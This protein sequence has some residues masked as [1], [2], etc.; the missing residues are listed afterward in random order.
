MHQKIR[1]GKAGNLILFVVDASGSMAAGKRM[2]AV[3]GSVFNLLKDAYQKRDMVGVISFRGVEAEILLEPTRSIDLAEGALANLPTGGRTPLAHGM[4]LAETV[5]I[6]YK[7]DNNVHPL[8]IILSDGKANV[9]LPGGGD[10]WRQVLLLAS[11]IA[12]MNVLTLVLD[13]ENGYLR[14]GRAAELA[15]VLNAECLS[16]EELTAE[17]ITRT[18]SGKIES[19]SKV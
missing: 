5:L 13:T 12:Q 6:Q 17:T 2:E 19:F 3:K 16:L 18:I 15:A 9:P 7:N 10:P 4:Q 14:F 11:Q 8:L 1:N